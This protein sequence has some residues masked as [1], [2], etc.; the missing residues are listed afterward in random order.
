MTILT[1]SIF[2]LLI[3]LINA[4]LFSRCDELMEEMYRGPKGDSTQSTRKALTQ[5][6]NIVD[7]RAV[8]EEGQL[9]LKWRTVD[10]DGNPL[11]TYGEAHYGTDGGM[12]ASTGESK[13][14][15]EQHV[16]RIDP[17]QNNTTYT[18]RIE[19]RT[20]ELSTVESTVFTYHTSEIQLDVTGVSFDS[21]GLPIAYVAYYARNAEGEGIETIGFVEW[22]PVGTSTW[23]NHQSTKA[24]LKHTS[25]IP[26]REPTTTAPPTTIGPP[27]VSGETIEYRVTVTD[28]LGQSASSQPDTVAVTLLDSGA[29]DTWNADDFESLP[30][31][32]WTMLIEQDRGNVVGGVN[33]E[34]DLRDQSEDRVFLTSPPG[35]S[36]PAFE[37]RVAKGDTVNPLGVDSEGISF[38]AKIYERVLLRYHMWL[39]D[40]SGI[41]GKYIH[42]G[43][44]RG[45]I[46][47]KYG[48]DNADYGTA[49]GGVN[50]M[51]PKR[52]EHSDGGKKNGIRLLASFS[53]G[54]LGSEY[55]GELISPTPPYIPPTDRWVPVDIIIDKNN[56]YELHVNGKEIIKTMGRDPIVGGSWTDCKKLWWR[57]RLMH[58]GT[59]SDSALIAN[60]DYSQWFGGFS[61]YAE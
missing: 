31:G 56:G 52:G 18:Y 2:V 21:S 14:K 42:F 24:Y 22:R 35:D 3:L 4:L 43:I 49:G 48:K 5:P 25:R 8:I 19:A 53:E 54:K 44:G 36:R 28:A 37:H 17:Y 46:G 27:L 13:A 29:G 20:D 30:E 26:A 23:Y 38:D 9:R 10:A 1:R 33:E 47:S 16:K 7:V 34:V 41:E 12:D 11:L 40:Y 61:V 32:D 55:Y 60:R 6:I 58:G 57:V 45:W 51:Q 50:T 15:Y 59:P 39:S